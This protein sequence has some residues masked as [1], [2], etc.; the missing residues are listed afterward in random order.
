MC[1]FY[2]KINIHIIFTM[3][4]YLLKCAHEFLNAS[5]KK[6]HWSL[7]LVLLLASIAPCAHLSH[8]AHPHHFYPF[9][10]GN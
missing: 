2:S 6:E 3:S 7:N 4:I 8:K 5:A 10:Y 9:I 1:V